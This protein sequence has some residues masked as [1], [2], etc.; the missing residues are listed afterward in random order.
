MDE[1]LK[2]SF[3]DALRK[4]ESKYVYNKFLLGHEVWFFKTKRK[5]KDHADV[6]HGLKMTMADKLGLHINNIAIVGSAKLG[7]SITPNAAK[8][9]RDFSDE[10]DIDIVVVSQELFRKSWS[11]FLEVKT[12]SHLRNYDRISSEVFRR[13][14]TLKNVDYK[15]K[16]FQEWSSKMDPCKRDLQAL[17]SIPADVNYRIYESWEDVERYH[18]EGLDKLKKLL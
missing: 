2:Q 5:L 1:E 14:V 11:T 7:F 4:C 9:F 6:Y 17:Y 12:K 10:S 8:M 18:L 15:Y 13:F 3:K 16:F